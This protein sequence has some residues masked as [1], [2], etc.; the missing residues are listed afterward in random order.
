MQQLGLSAPSE[1]ITG[2]TIPRDGSF[3]VCDHDEV[4]RVVI[5]PPLRTEESDHEP[6]AFMAQRDDFL[7]MGVGNGGSVLKHGETE[8]SYDFDPCRDHVTVTCAAGGQ[9]RQIE[10]RTFSGDWFAASLSVDGRHLVLAEPY[11]IELY[12]LT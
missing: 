12:A 5:G 7:G 10:F 8:I 9:R 3:Y 11:R 1:R 2:F 6:Y 4:W